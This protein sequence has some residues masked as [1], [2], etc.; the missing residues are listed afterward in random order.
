MSMFG[1]ARKIWKNSKVVRPA[2]WFCYRKVT[3]AF[4]KTA[5][6]KAY[7]QK[8]SDDR[9]DKLLPPFYNAHR[10][11]PVDEKKVLF[12]EAVQPKLT[13][14]VQLICDR[15]EESGE[16]TIHK[17]FLRTDFVHRKEW[18]KNCEKFLED[19]ATAK[20]VFVTEG[21]PVLSCVTLRPE[22]VVFQTWHGCGAFKKFGFSTASTAYGDSLE[23]HLRHPIYKNYTYVTVS[24]PEV[25]WAFVEAMHLQGHEDIVRPVGVSRTDVFFDKDRIKQAFA[26]VC[27]LFPAARGKKIILYAPTFRGDSTSSAY[28]PDKLDIRAMQKALGDQYVLIVKHHQLVRELPKVPEDLKG[29]FVYDGSKNMSIDDLLMTADICISDYSSLIFEYSL[30]ERPM[31][32]FAYDLEKYFDK[33]GFYYDYSEMAPGPICKTTDE[34]IECIRHPEKHFDKAKVHAFRQKFMS[35]CDG[36][37][38]DRILALMGAGNLSDN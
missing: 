28:A 18:E 4:R 10:S 25:V 35:A 22:T 33:R 30:F 16:Y 11:E 34:L 20:Y 31:L 7:Y 19:L 14:N 3:R 24:S 23:K 36:H 29:S 2:Y 17:H 26:N 5:A 8:K 37:S 6:G 27:R 9:Y 1:K 12:M 15:L 21:S 13:N 38:T 32:F